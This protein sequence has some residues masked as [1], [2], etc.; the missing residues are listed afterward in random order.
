M[1][2]VSIVQQASEI[3]DGIEQ[4]QRAA[5]WRDGLHVNERG[6]V[7]GTA[8][9]VMHALEHNPDLAG[10]VKYNAFTRSQML[11]AKPPW[12]VGKFTPR[13]WRD[14]DDSE[15]LIYLQSSGVPVKA[16]TTV[17]ET[18]A[19]VARR[20][21]FDPLVCYLDGLQW[22]SEPRLSGWL[23]VYLGAEHSELNKAIGRAFLISAIAR[24]Y[25]PGCQADHA[26]VLEGIQGAG[27]SE[28]VRALG[29]PWVL[30]DLPPLHSDGAMQALAGNWFVELS[31]LSA[32]NRSQVEAVK[33][34]LTRRIDKYRPPYARHFVEYG[35]RC[36]FIAT[37]NEDRYLRD[38]TGNRR[39]WPVRCGDIKLDWLRDDR[40]QLLA[41]AAQAYRSGEAWYLTDKQ[42]QR[43][44]EAAQLDRVEADPWV[45]E[46]AAFT[47]DRTTTTTADLLQMLD[48]PRGKSAAHHARRLAGLM[49]ELGWSDRRIKRDGRDAIQ[50]RRP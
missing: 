7:E 49:R 28:T 19:A 42:L 22:D 21:A 25:E 46:I 8:V 5:A 36:V 39:F 3:S 20:H 33:S 1:R 34:F 2:P 35:R 16:A 23:S 24:A 29:G 27:K 10:I 32:M 17:A 41:E 45:A 15:L 40:D 18:V 30:E 50:W 44:A 47:K 6:R 12:E 4:R 43:E 14:S 11:M 9:N 31:E 13:A 26:L 37:T 38:R 48:I